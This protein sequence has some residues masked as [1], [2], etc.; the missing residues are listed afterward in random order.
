MGQNDAENFT[1]ENMKIVFIYP[2]VT[3]ENLPSPQIEYYVRA[4]ARNGVGPSRSV[5]CY[6]S[7]GW[8][9]AA[10]VYSRG[11]VRLP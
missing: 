5:N 9:P 3:F 4:K 6:R 10:L 2:P 8:P 1:H 7:L 11:I